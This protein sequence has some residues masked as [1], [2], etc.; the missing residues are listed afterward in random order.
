[1]NK[2]LINYIEENILGEYNKND[3]GHDINHIEYV[4]KRSL[5]FA[6]EIKDININM[7]YTVASYHDIAHHINKD[8]HEEL[9]SEILYNDKNLRKYFT[10]EEINI[11]KEAIIDHRSSLNY[12]PRSIYGK[13]ISS[14]DKNVK[15]EDI[16]KRTYEYR[17]ANYKDDN[18]NDIIEESYN[19]IL[20]K[21]GKK[22]YAVNKIYFKDKEYDKYLKD[23]DNLLNDKEKFIKV[24]LRV[25]N[26]EIND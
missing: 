3:K 23:L 7:V 8:K 20:N 13:I 12:E 10:E 9:S 6:R 25:N 15:V 14:A 22:G 17:I 19:H 21:Y 16:I 26:I 24:Y 18:I 11:M 2:E 1:M 4:I 5:K